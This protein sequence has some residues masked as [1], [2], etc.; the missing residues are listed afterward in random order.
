MKHWT[1]AVAAGCTPVLT[2]CLF[3]PFDVYSANAI[4]STRWRPELAELWVWVMRR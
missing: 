2:L 4:T 1:T 3:G